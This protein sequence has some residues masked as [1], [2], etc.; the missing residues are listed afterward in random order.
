VNATL[1]KRNME[2]AL[3]PLEH[4]ANTNH[5]NTGRETPLSLTQAGYLESVEI[6]FEPHVNVNLVR[7][8][9]GETPLELAAQL[10]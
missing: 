8:W 10:G 5:M 3:L 9:T 1:A 4:G 7:N 2:I 6:L